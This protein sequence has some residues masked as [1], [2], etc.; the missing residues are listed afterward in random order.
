MKKEQI[1][2]KLA[3]QMELLDKLFK[4]KYLPV[5]LRLL[6]CDR[7]FRLLEMM[8]ALDFLE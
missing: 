7:F 3:E 4:K 6:V 8:L 1:K 5:R 2:E